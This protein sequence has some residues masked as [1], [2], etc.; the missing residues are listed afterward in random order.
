MFESLEGNG[1][2]SVRER[3]LALLLSV[4]IHGLIIALMVVLPL[5]FFRLLPENDLLTILIAP[6]EPPPPL[7]PPIPH[8]NN[9][10]RLKAEYRAN[11]SWTTQ[12]SPDSVPKGIPAPGNELPM[13]EVALG[14]FGF[15][16]G[17]SGIAGPAGTGIFPSGIGLMSP[18]PPVPPPPA[19][20]RMPQPVGGSVQESKLIRKV[21]PAY[22]D[23]ARRAHVED[24]VS[25]EVTVDEEGNVTD[26]KVV[27]GHPLLIEDAVRAVRQWKYSRL[28]STASRSRW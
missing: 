6:P 23:L 15:G 24:V 2:R 26:V 16:P 12:F 8:Q 21:L 20:R 9:S 3:L 5:L 17:I 28:C 7:P 11:V 25:L 22:P 10:A 13:V 19:P 1:C 18:P 4:F 14:I 27:R